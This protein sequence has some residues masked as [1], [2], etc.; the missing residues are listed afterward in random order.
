MTEQ[1]NTLTPIQKDLY[2]FIIDIH[3]KI[4]GGDATLDEAIELIDYISKF[5]ALDASVIII[6]TGK[7]ATKQQKFALWFNQN[8]NEFERIFHLV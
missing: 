8:I 2:D 6:E 3:R 1:L 4:T 5:N 7:F